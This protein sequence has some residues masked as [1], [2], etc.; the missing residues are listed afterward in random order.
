MK[1]AQRRDIKT[2][3]YHF[4]PIRTVSTGNCSFIIIF[5]FLG[6]NR[7]VRTPGQ[8]RSIVETGSRNQKVCRFF[9][10][11]LSR[12]WVLN[13]FLGHSLKERFFEIASTGSDI[14]YYSDAAK[15]IEMEKQYAVKNM[16]GVC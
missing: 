2:R 1:T 3:T 6:G 5:I 16:M 10:L 15:V 9:L 14:L 13:H 8:I 12:S 4:F 7:Y 11:F